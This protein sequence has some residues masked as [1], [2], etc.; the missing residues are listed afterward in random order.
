MFGMT[1]DRRTAHAAR[2]REL[3][4]RRA[5]CAVSSRRARTRRV[6]AGKKNSQKKSFGTPP[7]KTPGAFDFEDWDQYLGG[8][9][10]SQYS[11]LAQ[12]DKSNVAG[13]RS[14]GPIR[15]ART[16][17][18][19]P[20]IVGNAMY[21]LAKSRSI[22][23]LDAATGREIWVHANEGAVGTRGMNYWQSEDGATSACCTSTAG[24]SRRSTRGPATRSRRSAKNGRVDLRVG[25]DGDTA[26]FARCRPTIRAESSRT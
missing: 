21:V 18:F 1:A 22:V 3:T 5:P 13:S 4:R 8:A 7:A 26:T 19:N 9:D 17:L 24:S 2:R 20:M 25:L 12:I 14:R 15:P 23:A 16:T 11:S 10:S 6:L